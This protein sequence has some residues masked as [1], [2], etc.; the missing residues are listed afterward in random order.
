MTD[1]EILENRVT[2]PKF[3]ITEEKCKKNR[4]REVTGGLVTERDFRLY[5]LKERMLC[6]YAC[7]SYTPFGDGHYCHVD[8]EEQKKTGSRC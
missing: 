3:K 8:K 5:E 1:N 7:P 6:C 4:V 2:D